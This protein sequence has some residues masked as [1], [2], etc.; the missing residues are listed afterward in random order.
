MLVQYFGCKGATFFC[1]EQSSANKKC[2]LCGFC[3]NGEY[4]IGL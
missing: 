4:R 1:I 3:I 2:H